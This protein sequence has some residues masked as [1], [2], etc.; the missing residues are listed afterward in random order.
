MKDW[1]WAMA[2]SSKP[3]SGSTTVR[4]DEVSKGVGEDM[5]ER[6]EQLGEAGAGIGMGDGK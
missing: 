4:E 1:L 6:K 5:C 3:Y 2:S